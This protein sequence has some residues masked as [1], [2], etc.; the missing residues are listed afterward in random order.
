ML[1]VGFEI[2]HL[3]Q[4]PGWGPHSEQQVGR[5][6]CPCMKPHAGPSAVTQGINCR[7]HPL[8]LWPCPLPH[9]PPNLGCLD[10][11]SPK[12]PSCWVP[13]TLCRTCLSGKRE[14]LHYR[15]HSGARR[16]RETILF[17]VNQETEGGGALYKWWRDTEE[18]RR[19]NT[20]QCSE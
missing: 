11:P 2:P 17:I 1:G 7:M 19:D 14:C 4:A 16:L 9:S 15:E 8:P 20:Q 3:Q 18:R 10:V 13:T 5:I 12:G 6:L